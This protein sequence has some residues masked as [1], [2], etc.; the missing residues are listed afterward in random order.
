MLEL[1]VVILI[2]SLLSVVAVIG[3]RGLSGA[4]KFNKALNDISGIL[5]QSRA[6]AI[7]QNTYVWVAFYEYAPAGNA[8][9]EVYSCAFASNDG[10]DPFDWTGTVALPSPGTIGSTT[11][12]PI[13]HLYHFKGL[14]LQTTSLPG[15]TGT[16]NFP[17]SS[18]AF[19]YT[20]RGDS[21]TLVLSNSNPVYWIIQF[22]P[23]GAARN[24]SNSIDSIWMGLQPSL[25]STTLDTKNIA[26]MK[27]NGLSGLTTIYRQ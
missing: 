18:P 27:V 11:L 12:L 2:V 10:T 16:P 19:Q 6:Y 7:A 3:L 22:T 4:G 20:A 5:E 13:T 24:N 8:P 23:R 1:L 9:L 26:S 25:S 14:H 21:G 15:V 17:A